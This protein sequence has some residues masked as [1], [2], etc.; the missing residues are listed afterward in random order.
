MREIERGYGGE[1]NRMM[2][3]RIR[4][5]DVLIDWDIEMIRAEMR[6]YRDV[7]VCVRESV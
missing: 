5:E 2:G 7:I 3:I 6:E 1:G 4:D